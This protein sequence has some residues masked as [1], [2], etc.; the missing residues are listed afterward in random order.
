MYGQP[1]YPPQQMGQMPPMEVMG[2]V[3]FSKKKQE[4]ME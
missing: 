2:K 4:D 1:A 3:Q